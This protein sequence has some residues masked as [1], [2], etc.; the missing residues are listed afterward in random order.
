MRLM[1]LKIFS[2]LFLFG[3]VFFFQIR[4][5]QFK[6]QFIREPTYHF[7]PPKSSFIRFLS[8]G[9]ETFVA[10]IYWMRAV[11]YYANMTEIGRIPEDLYYLSDF[12]TDLDPLFEY[13]YYSAG[14][15]LTFE[16]GNHRH[17]RAI[18]EKGKEA[19]PESWRIPFMLGFSE[20]FLM[21]DYE[22]AALNLEEAGRLAEHHSWVFLA[23]RIRAEKGN[24]MLSIHFL[25]QQLRHTKEP[26]WRQK[27]EKHIK[28]LWI[29]V[30]INNLNAR[31][32]EYHREHGSWASSWQELYNAGIMNPS[33]MP[34]EPFGGEYIIDPETHLADTTSG[35]RLMVYEHPGV[36]DKW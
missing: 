22:N 30:H 19:L 23:A 11:Q 27:I 25:N 6:K 2:V 1:F 31:L 9:H 18:L 33:E 17:I 5:D 3:S 36:V 24:P 28:Q 14:L 16:N 35:Q 7:R 34:R 26:Y 20:Y 15:V 21:R 10:D 13:G 12:I 8:L 29:S 4:I 32:E